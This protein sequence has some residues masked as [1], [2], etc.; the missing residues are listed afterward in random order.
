LIERL[1]AELDVPL[2]ERNLLHL[3]AGFAPPYPERQLTD[4]TAARRAVDSVL[5]GLE[6]NPAVAVDVGWDLVA[7]NRAAGVFL[8]GV[9]EELRRPPINMIRMTLAP[10]GLASQISNLAS[11]RAEVM[12][13]LQR[14]L[15]RTADP[16]L[17]ALIDEFRAGSGPAEDDH[18]EQAAGNDLVVPLEL[19]TEHGDLTFLYTTTVFGSPRDV[20][21]DEIA[22]ET[23]FPADEHTARVLHNLVDHSVADR[24]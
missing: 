2:R 23:F 7:A 6:P 12:R 3:A 16:R 8:G 14:Q 4:L 1:C 20:T 9:S 5:R 17:L 15:E 22:I 18:A 21:L 24:R 19:A 10:G 11:W 13:R